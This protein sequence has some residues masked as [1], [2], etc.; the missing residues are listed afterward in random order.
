MN[1]L[2]QLKRLTTV[3]SDTGDIASIKQY[4]PQD[5]TTNPSL[6][7]KAANMPQ[8]A[9]LLDEAL[10]FAKQKSSQKSDI[11][12]LATSKVCVN[13]GVEIL[14]IIPGRIST[15][16]DARLSF[17][18]QA[19]IEQARELIKLYKEAGIER[20]RV[21]IKIV[22]TWEG[23]EAARVL[24]KEG[25]HCNLTLMFSLVQAI[26]AAKAG[27]FLISPFVGRIYD[28]YKKRDNKEYSP[29]EDP[30]V[31]SVQNIY[32]Y[33]RHFDLPTIVMGASFRTAGQ[34]EALAGCDYL[35]IS[36]NLMAEL[37]RDEGSL[38]PSLSLEKAKASN[39]KPLDC[40]E[41]AMRW[42]LND[43]AM[44][45]EKLAEGIR[46]FAADIASLEKIFI[47]KM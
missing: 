28:W 43:D 20:E 46:I 32:N 13:F 9:Y 19:T 29:Q 5:S 41:K 35:T 45:T 33:L 17:D 27:A 3:V 39:I 2:E 14:K 22:S 18:T 31:I 21:L 47:T 11:L 6:I 38:K 23:I 10:S 34:I 25:I 24:E 15:E 8:Y 30:G 40:D 7:L 12:K 26:A 44:A 36:P 1:K 42:A 37:Q 4:S 16:V